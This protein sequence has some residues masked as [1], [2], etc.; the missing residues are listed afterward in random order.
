AEDR[1]ICGRDSNGRELERDR[2]RDT[3]HLDGG[4]VRMAT[5]PLDVQALLEEGLQQ[6]GRELGIPDGTVIGH[7]HL[8][9]ADLRKT[10]QFY[11]AV[12]GFDLM[13]QMPSALFVS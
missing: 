11:R 3:W 12:L 6:S 9:V 2:P 10:E 8:R 5:D 4:Q 7:V 1:Y 13:A